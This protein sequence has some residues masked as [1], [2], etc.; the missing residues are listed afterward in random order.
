MKE[1]MVN[2]KKEGKFYNKWW[3]WLLVF[4][5]LIGIV[6]NVQGD[7]SSNSQKKESEAEQSTQ[8]SNG[9]LIY[10]KNTKAKDF[11]NLH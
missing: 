5:F 10:L 11:Y 1:R 4:L 3:F 2:M 8:K 7:N 6:S 9:S